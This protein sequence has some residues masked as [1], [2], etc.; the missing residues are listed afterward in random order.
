MTDSQIQS[1]L[2][3]THRAVREANVGQ[4]LPFLLVLQ[5]DERHVGTFA[6]GVPMGE[7]MRRVAIAAI[8]EART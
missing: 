6:N 3:A 5:F 2:E 4:P 8:L 1:I 7:K